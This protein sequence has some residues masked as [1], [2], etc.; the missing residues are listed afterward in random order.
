MWE[1]RSCQK[2]DECFVCVNQC[3]DIFGGK[4]LEII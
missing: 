1:I 2:S 3:V 4:A